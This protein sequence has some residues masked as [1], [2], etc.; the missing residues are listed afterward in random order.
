MPL[1]PHP[2]FPFDFH[3]LGVFQMAMASIFCFKP[4]QQIAIK[5]MHMF[6]VSSFQ[7]ELRSFVSFSSLAVRLI[8]VGKV[9]YLMTIIKHRREFPS[10][11][12]EFHPI[13]I[14][15]FQAQRVESS[16]S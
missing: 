5:L 2:L 10:P 1:F 8:D 14:L 13:E 9:D 16:F 15:E 3:I 4:H 11:R 7:I 12:W 6:N